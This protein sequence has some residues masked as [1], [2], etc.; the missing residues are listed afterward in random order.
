MTKLNKYIILRDRARLHA[1]QVFGTLLGNLTLPRADESTPELEVAQ[2]SKKDILDVHS[3]PTTVG[4]AP[5]MPLLLFEPTATRAADPFTAACTWGVEAT[6]AAASPYTGEG[7]VVAVLDTGIDAAH[8]AFAGVQLVK[9]DFTGLG[10][11]DTRGHGTH[12]AATLF[13]RQGPAPGR[14]GVAPGVRKALIGR[15][16]DDHGRGSAETLYR[17]ML[18]A[19]EAGAHVLSMSL[20]FDFPKYV[21]LMVADGRPAGDATALALESYRANIRMFESIGRILL[22]GAFGRSAVIVAAAGNSCDRAGTPPSERFVGP[23]AEAPDFVAVGALR[24]SGAPHDRLTVADFSNSGPQLCA[25]G[26][27]IYSAFPGGEYRMMTGTSM[28]APHVAGVAALWAQKLMQGTPGTLNAGLLRSRLIG[29][30]STTRLAPGFDGLDVGTG[31]V[32]APLA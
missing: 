10:E 18:W 2:L 30:A 17:A 12:C 15:V 4:I 29:Q 31:L 6:G 22:A 3:D 13:G 26:V 7:V 20:G 24:S 5:P 8:P 32:Q 9:R 28:A 14:I 19:H 21:D 16:I 1:T 11:G 27:D 23:P 25:P